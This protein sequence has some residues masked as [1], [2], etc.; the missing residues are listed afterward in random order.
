MLGRNDALG[1]HALG[2]G[3]EG[4]AGGPQGLARR[5]L[6]RRRADPELQEEFSKLGAMPDPSLDTPREGGRAP[7]QQL[8]EAERDFLVKTGRA[9]R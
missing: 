2:G 3:A 8:A 9:Q 5:R 6:P 7:W 4:G 1:R